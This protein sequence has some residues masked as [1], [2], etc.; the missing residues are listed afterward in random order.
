VVIDGPRRRDVPALPPI[1]VR[2]AIVNAV[3]HAD[4]S[5]P[6]GPLRIAVFADR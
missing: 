5:Q 4:Y 6:G 1:A 3:A 2:E